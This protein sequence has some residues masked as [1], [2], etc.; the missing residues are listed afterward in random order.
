MSVF[1]VETPVCH[2][3]FVIMSLK[4]NILNIKEYS[5]FQNGIATILFRGGKHG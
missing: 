3:D 4:E 2:Y 5:S 1:S